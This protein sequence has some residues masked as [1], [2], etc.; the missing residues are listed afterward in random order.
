MKDMLNA[1][2]FMKSIATVLADEKISQTGFPISY[3]TWHT[4]IQYIHANSLAYTAHTYTYT[5]RLQPHKYACGHN[6]TYTHTYT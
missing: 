5:V 1:A 3:H 4:Y 2:Q 6:L